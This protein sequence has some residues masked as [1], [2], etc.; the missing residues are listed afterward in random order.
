MSQDRVRGLHKGNGL[1]AEDDGWSWRE[2]PVWVVHIVMATLH[3]ANAGKTLA[4]S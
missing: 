4:G 2:L 1:W 3:G